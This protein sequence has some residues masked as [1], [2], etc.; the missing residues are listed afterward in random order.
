[1][2]DDV[3]FP[4]G[5]P[6]DLL[7]MVW[8]TARMQQSRVRLEERASAAETSDET[9]K[10]LA[11]RTAEYDAQLEK[12]RATWRGQS[13]DQ[14]IAIAESAVDENEGFTRELVSSATALLSADA[15]PTNAES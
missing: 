13:S 9:K 10:L 12:Y 15:A 5:V 14:K 4:E 3:V 6:L 1:M 11:K 8:H 7:H 2:A